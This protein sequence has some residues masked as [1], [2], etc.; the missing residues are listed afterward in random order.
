[1]LYELS[2][3]VASD[4]ELAADPDLVM[5]TLKAVRTLLRGG[6]GTSKV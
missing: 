6:R 2:Q 4:I 3:T 5:D 1:M